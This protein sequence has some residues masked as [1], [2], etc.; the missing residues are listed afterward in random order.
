VFIKPT[1]WV[2]IESNSYLIRKF[3]YFCGTRTDPATETK[4]TRAAGR[5]AAGFVLC[6]PFRQF[7]MT[8]NFAPSSGT[9]T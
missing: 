4:S 7:I 9:I 3:H 6:S 5:R 8:S 1:K 2:L